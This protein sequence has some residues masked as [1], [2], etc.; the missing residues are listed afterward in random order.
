[1]SQY[2]PKELDN[3]CRAFFEAFEKV[4]EEATSLRD[5]CKHS[6]KKKLGE[7][8]KC[9]AHDEAL[10]GMVLH[11][12][13]VKEVCRKGMTAEGSE[14]PEKKFQGAVA[15]C[16]RAATQ[17]ETKHGVG[18]IKQKLEDGVAED[19]IASLVGMRWP[20]TLFEKTRECSPQ[21]IESSKN[22]CIILDIGVKD[23]NIHKLL[24]LKAP[25]ALK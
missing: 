1:M 21:E 7:M 9:S 16:V 18:W 13:S 23:I 8:I 24:A 14:H 19:E 2:D 10:T 20:T 4:Q 5:L 15:N 17:T 25:R 22:T 12:G 3:I 6:P 11:K